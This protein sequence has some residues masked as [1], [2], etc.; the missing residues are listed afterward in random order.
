MPWCAG[1]GHCTIAKEG[2]ARWETEK[3]LLKT[4]NN[5]KKH[6]EDAEVTVSLFQDMIVEKTHCS[7]TP[8]TLVLLPAHVLVR[9]AII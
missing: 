5:N 2:G 3:R 7:K 8:K 1:S 6:Q 4:N 9:C